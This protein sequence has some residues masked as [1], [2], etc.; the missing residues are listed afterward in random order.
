MFADAELELKSVVEL[1]NKAMRIAR[2]SGMFT[3]IARTYRTLYEELRVVG[4]AHTDA[5]E[6][7][8]RNVPSGNGN[9]K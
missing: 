1:N 8:K 2:E 9:Q 7:V 3:E 6:I 4:F 5:M